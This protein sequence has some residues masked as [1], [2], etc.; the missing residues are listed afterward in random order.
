MGGFGGNG[1]FGGKSTSYMCSYFKKKLGHTLASRF[2]VAITE[3][4]SLKYRRP[5]LIVIFLYI[6]LTFKGGVGRMGK[7]CGT[8]AFFFLCSSYSAQCMLLHITHCAVSV[9]VFW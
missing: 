7:K 1:K 5:A 6:C 4:Y 8:C 3:D 9:C 2:H